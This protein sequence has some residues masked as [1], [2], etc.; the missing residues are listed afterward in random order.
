LLRQVAFEAVA[1]L[2][3]LASL[4]VDVLLVLKGLR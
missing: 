1:V 3:L 2:A 4:T